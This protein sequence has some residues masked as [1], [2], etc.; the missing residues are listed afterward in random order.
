MASA[1]KLLSLFLSIF[2]LAVSVRAQ[3]PV[4][5]SIAIDE[6][7]SILICY[8]SFPNSPAIVHIF[9]TTLGILSQTDTEIHAAIPVSGHA[10]AGPVIVEIGGQKSDSKLI[11][12]L[13]L[14]ISI[15]WDYFA[16][17]G[18]EEYANFTDNLSLRAD[19][20]RLLTSRDSI[21]VRPSRISSYVHSAGGSSGMHGSEYGGPVFDSTGI[22]YWTYRIF[23]NADSN[24]YEIVH[25][26]FSECCYY[27]CD[28][29]PL[30]KSFGLGPF[31]L[32]GPAPNC[33]LNPEEPPFNFGGNSGA[34]WSE[35]A[36]TEF[37]P[38][39]NERVKA[40]LS[41]KMFSISLINLN[42]K[43]SAKLTSA[44]PSAR[45]DIYDILGHR[46]VTLTSE[47]QSGENFILLD[48]PVL[49]PGIYIVRAQSG[50]DVRSIKF[51]QQ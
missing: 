22:C 28:P 6:D 17:D 25:P 49:M 47:L 26:C 21:Q 44:L 34:G 36:P 43:L 9:D 4:L 11:T 51:I 38:D 37:P 41:D 40:D 2:S 20:E 27:P 18:G 7:S 48:S 39:L 31:R 19:L 33:L 46:L 45:I 42:G 1:M 24:N 29:I 23:W 12:Y 16:S 5:D 14:S 32:S 35:T 13:H 3:T 8:G 30:T 50:S 15:H 10:A